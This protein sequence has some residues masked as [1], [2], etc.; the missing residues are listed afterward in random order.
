[1]TKP[2]GRIYKNKV[3]VSIDAT[4]LYNVWPVGSI[5]ISVINVNPSEY[6]GGAWESFGVGRCLV[7]V[8][9]SQT[10]FNTVLKEGGGKDL[11][12]HTHTQ[13]SCT[14]PGN[15]SHNTWNYFSFKHSSGTVTT[16]CTGEP[17][18]GRGNATSA[19]GGHTHTITLNDTGTG[20]SGNLQPYITIYMWRRT[21]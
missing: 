18:D 11:Q 17:S 6:F 21:S 7:G 12:K 16:A 19:A 5:Y 20:D 4:D 2:Y 1:M 3:N 13:K 10:E 8:D 15:H 14:S 9:T